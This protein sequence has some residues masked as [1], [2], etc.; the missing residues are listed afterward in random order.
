MSF[1]PFLHRV[2]ERQDLNSDESREAMSLI[3]SGDVS[4]AQLAAF[5]VAL[6][7]K[8]ETADEIIGFARAM[9]ARVTRVE[10]S[11]NSEPLL[12]TCGTGGD[13]LSTFNIS[14]IAAF[15]VAGAGVRVAKHG[16]R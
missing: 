8:G 12:D 15:V 14:T 7:M 1:L 11:W 2:C 6:S 10:A 16:N 4:T 3:L 13:T 9:R 5:L